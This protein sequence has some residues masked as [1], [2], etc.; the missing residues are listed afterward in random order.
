MKLEVFSIM[1]SNIEKSQMPQI[2]ESLKTC[3]NLK[4]VNLS[5][6]Y[7]KSSSISV[8]Q[9]LKSLTFI[10]VVALNN[11][12][13]GTKGIHNIL[14]ALKDKPCLKELYFAGNEIGDEGMKK[15]NNFFAYEFKGLRALSLVNNNITEVGAKSLSCF[16]QSKTQL[17]YLRLGNN[18]LKAT[19]VYVILSVFIGKG[20]LNDFDVGN[21]EIGDEGSNHILFF[22]NQQHNLKY[23]NIKNNGIS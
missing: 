4:V 14:N 20:Q 7:L 12:L 9:M 5:G 17:Q 3:S 10:E 23:L 8:A 2:L 1:N 21:N 18:K 19:G 22:L 15:V 6:N 16:L 13:I 11:S